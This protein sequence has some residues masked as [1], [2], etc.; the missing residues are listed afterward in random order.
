MALWSDWFRG[1]VRGSVGN[2][3]LYS[4]PLNHPKIR[5]AIAECVCLCICDVH[6]SASPSCAL[7]HN[8]TLHIDFYQWA[9]RQLAGAGVE[10]KR[11]REREREG[12]DER[13]EQNRVEGRTEQRLQT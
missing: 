2:Q 1:F 12:E 13:E 6:C 3:T 7:A 5:Y 9:L 4:T 11:E 8:Q 10:E